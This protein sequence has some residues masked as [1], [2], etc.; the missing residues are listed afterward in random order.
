MIMLAFQELGGSP[1]EKYTLDGFSATRQFIVPW[2]QRAAFVQAVF[3]NSTQPP[4][5][6][7][8]IYPGRTDVFAYTLDFEPLEPD[9]IGVRTL[10]NLKTD[11]VDYDGSF[12]KATVK[13]GAADG[14]DRDDLPIE[15]DGTS[16]TYRMAIDVEESLLPGNGWVWT[17]T[18]I[19]IGADVTKKIP[20][21]EH[22]VTWSYVVN[23]PWTAIAA[24]QGKVNASPFLGCAAGTLLFRGAEA[25]KLYR[26]GAGIEDDTASFAWAIRYT[27]RE[28]SVKMNGQVYGWN[29]FYRESSGNWVPIQHGSSP[30]YDSGDFNSLFVA[31]LPME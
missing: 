2:E 16:L 12:A 18:A 27:F 11:L 1:H 7:R 4:G 17:D 15:E 26:R 6:R 3:G 10:A 24:C 9:M 29:H 14:R 19:P 25:N 13:Y 28:R 5:E 21:T 31:E 8:L 22:I 23:P 20:V 30:L